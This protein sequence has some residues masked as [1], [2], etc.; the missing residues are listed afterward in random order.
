V[1]IENARHAQNSLW[2]AWGGFGC[3]YNARGQAVYAKNL[4]DGRESQWERT[5]FLGIVKSESLQKWFENMSVKSENMQFYFQHNAQTTQERTQVEIKD[6]CDKATSILKKTRDGD[7]LDPQDLKLIE[8]AV[9]GF[10]NEIGINAFENLHYSVVVSE[11]YLKPYLHGIEH[12]TCDHE[13]YIYYKDI[14]VEH[15]NRDYVQPECIN[16]SLT[17][18][19]NDELTHENEFD[20]SEDCEL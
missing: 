6:T 11:A 3:N 5:D 2:I 19:D 4:F 13:G 20:E 9:N 18:S 15:Y 16:A 10:L 1:L 12:M 17:I 7:L 14:H 8:S